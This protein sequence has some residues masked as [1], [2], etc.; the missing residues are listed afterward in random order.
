MDVME[1]ADNQAESGVISTL[2][3]HP[4]FILHTD[5][6]KPGYCYTKKAL[7]ISM[8]STFLVCCRATKRCKKLLKNIICHLFKN[9]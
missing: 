6:L 5:Y 8:L 4:E 1:L 3:Y 9:T 2:V 7:I